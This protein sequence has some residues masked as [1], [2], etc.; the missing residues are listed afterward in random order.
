MTYQFPVVENDHGIR[1][2]AGFGS[3]RC[4]YCKQSIGQYHKDDC[5]C[6]RKEVSFRIYFNGIYIGVWETDEPAYQTLEGAEF[7]MN[8]SSWC[9]K[10]ILDG[11]FKGHADMMLQAVEEG[12]CLCDELTFRVLRMS[13]DLFT[14][15]P[16]KSQL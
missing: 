1:P 11:G 14:R 2:E 6:I 9:S 4:L 5:V 15:P 3:D 12:S 10:N 16:F 7:H 8:E 13:E